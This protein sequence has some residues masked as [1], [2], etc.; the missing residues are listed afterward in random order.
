MTGAT[1]A[2]RCLDNGSGACQMAGLAGDVQ[3]H[4]DYLAVRWH[5]LAGA[6]SLAHSN[7]H[8]KNLQA[9]QGPT[10][11]VIMAGIL[12]SG[13]QLWR[14]TMVPLLCAHGGKRSRTDNSIAGSA[15]IHIHIHNIRN[16]TLG[17]DGARYALNNG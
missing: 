14:G 9:R 16:E 7:A 2:G 10:V 11:R 5:W 13:W 4:R 3:L 8:R 6:R 12:N 1:R 15:D 17:R